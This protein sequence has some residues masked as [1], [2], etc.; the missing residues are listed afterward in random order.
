M[1]RKEIPEIDKA[2]FSRLYE[3]IQKKIASASNNFKSV[4]AINNIVKALVY[5]PGALNPQS[6][7]HRKLMAKELLEELE[8]FNGLTDIKQE[9]L[10]AFNKNCGKI[11]NDHIGEL[12]S[13]KG[14]LN[15]IKNLI[16]HAC[17]WIGI[18]PQAVIKMSHEFSKSVTFK[19]ELQKIRKGSEFISHEAQ[20]ELNISIMLK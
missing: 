4:K 16:N 15:S 7:E 11:I 10:T 5:F 12:A 9:H 8:R 17:N 1:G 18:A 20:K 6:D 2:D 13:E 3:S 19:D 14:F